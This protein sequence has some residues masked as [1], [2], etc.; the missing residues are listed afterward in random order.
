MTPNDPLLRQLSEASR[1]YRDPLAAVDF[2]RLDARDW[3]LPEEALSV[4][5]LPE[6][7]TLADAVKRRLSQYEFI[8]VMCM[9]LWLESLFMER[10]SRRLVPGLPRSQHEYFLHE[11]REEAGHS[12]MF[13]AAIEASGLAVPAVA[14]RPPLL[15]DLLGRRAPANGALFWLAAVIGEDVPDK[16]NRYVRRRSA[17]INPAVTQICALHVM[18]EARHIAAAR[19]HLDAV[20]AQAGKFKRSALAALSRA[21]L[22]RMA[23]AFYY[24]PAMFYELAGLAHGGRWSEAALGNAVHRDFVARQLAPTRRMLSEIL[25]KNK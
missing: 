1:R 23:A 5:G 3:W 20:L 14:W 2:S 13:L 21:L 4:Y 16:F 6:Y 19:T 17:D 24:P 8:N 25:N 9:G 15:P 10:I 22:A 18:D 12:L 7:T 11:V